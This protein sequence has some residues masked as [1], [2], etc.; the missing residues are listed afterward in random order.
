[1]ASE[2]Q[3]KFFA[4]KSAMAN[5]VKQLLFDLDPKAQQ[6][7]AQVRQ[8][9][10]KMDCVGHLRA[11]NEGEAIKIDDRTLF[12][13]QGEEGSAGK[14]EHVKAYNECL[15]GCEKPMRELRLETEFQTREF[16]INLNECFYFCRQNETAGEYS[17][18][19]QCL[20]RC[21]NIHQVMLGKVE[22]KLHREYD[23]RIQNLL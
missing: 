8:C 21:L 6:V 14:A 1:M 20:Q 11:L 19:F 23:R 7:Q 5:Q 9:V 22:A 16:Q 18:Q 2:E 13:K 10:H 4:H 12:L 15:L 3:S 17:S